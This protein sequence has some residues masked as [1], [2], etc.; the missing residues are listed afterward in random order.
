MVY[1]KETTAMTEYA[2]DSGP[3]PDDEILIYR[4][5]SAL[6]FYNASYFAERISRRAESRKD[7]RLI[8]IDARPINMIDLTALSVLRDLIRKFNEEDVTVVFAGANESFKSSVTR[9]LESNNLNTDIF[10]AD[11]HSVFLRQ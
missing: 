6:F 8:A 3:P 5:D 11:I 10:H 2:A 1:D 4:F 7:L 9:E